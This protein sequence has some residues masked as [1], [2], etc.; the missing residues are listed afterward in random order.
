MDKLTQKNSKFSNNQIDLERKT[1]PYYIE[2]SLIIT[3]MKII[4]R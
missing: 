2:S 1:Y 4:I 3:L